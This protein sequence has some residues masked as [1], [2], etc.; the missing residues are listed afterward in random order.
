MIYASIKGDASGT[1]CV[2]GDIA[3]TEGAPRWWFDAECL[4]KPFVMW[5]CAERLGL[6]A[7][8]A[9]NVGNVRD[10]LEHETLARFPSALEWLFSPDDL[11]D[12][13]RQAIRGGHLQTDVGYS[14]VAS[15]VA[16]LATAFGPDTTAHAAAVSE[17]L[18]AL[19]LPASLL[20]WSS[21]SDNVT[22]VPSS[23]CISTSPYFPTLCAGYTRRL[24]PEFGGLMRLD[25]L[26]AA[27]TAK[28]QIMNGRSDYGTYLTSRDPD[29][30]WD[31]TW[32][33]VTRFVGGWEL[34]EDNQ[35]ALRS[36]A[37]G[38]RAAID[39]SSLSWTIDLRE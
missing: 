17:A 10:V 6:D 30:R 31:E 32:N 20:Q 28:C 29:R 35:L 19:D 21:L 23:E 16:L 8:V 15:S 18:D 14:E 37:S 36:P 4:T 22:V 24:G 11:R 7:Q 34:T 33:R 26:A 1:L 38:V 39:R 5:A 25:S 13:I 27:L 9:G 3:V 12:E 2:T